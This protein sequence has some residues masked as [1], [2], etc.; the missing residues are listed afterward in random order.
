MEHTHAHTHTHTHTDRQLTGGSQLSHSTLCLAVSVSLSVHTHTQSVTSFLLVSFMHHNSCCYIFKNSLGTTGF[1]DI[2]D[3][4]FTFIFFFL[5]FKFLILHV[6]M[7]SLCLTNNRCIIKVVLNHLQL[8]VSLYPWNNSIFSVKYFLKLFFP[9]RPFGIC[10]FQRAADAPH[11]WV[12]S[13]KS[14]KV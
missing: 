5:F 6:F 3:F 12:Y 11:L 1:N 7:L 2:C 8:I 10:W 4:P 14:V 9:P 13:D